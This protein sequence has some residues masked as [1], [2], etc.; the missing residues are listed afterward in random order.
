MGAGGDEVAVGPDDQDLAVV[1]EA[2]GGDLRFGDAFAGHRFG[3]VAPDFLD[4]HGIFGHTSGV[5]RAFWG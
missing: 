2:E 3:G 5:V 1:G 4:V